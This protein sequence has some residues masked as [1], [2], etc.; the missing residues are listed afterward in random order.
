MELPDDVQEEIKEVTAKEA[1]VNRKTLH[2]AVD[3]MDRARQVYEEAVQARS[4]LHSQWR[5][6][7]AESVKLWQGHAANFQSQDTQLTERIQQAKWVPLSLREM[8]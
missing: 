8:P 7:L 2:Q 6:F 5:T 1:K 4:Q 3:A